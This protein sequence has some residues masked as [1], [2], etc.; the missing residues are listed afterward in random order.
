MSLDQ[1]VFA[2]PFVA[3]LLAAF[4]LTQG[5]GTEGVKRKLDKDWWNTLVAN[6]KIWP[7]VQMITFSVLP[8]KLRVVF[9]QIVAVGWNSYLAWV[10]HRD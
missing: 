4:T 7:A 6:W 1:L 10:A 3:T 9:V 5:K 2:P 8:L